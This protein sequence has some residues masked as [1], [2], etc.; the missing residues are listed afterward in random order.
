MRIF[1]NTAFVLL[2]IHIVIMQPTYGKSICYCQTNL[3][4][5]EE[6]SES[7]LLLFPKRGLDNTRRMLLFNNLDGTCSAG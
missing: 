1:T 3:F 4:L 6:L 5:K 7:N 2:A